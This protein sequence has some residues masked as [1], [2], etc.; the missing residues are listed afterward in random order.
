MRPK[1]SVL[2]TVVVQGLAVLT[3]LGLGALLIMVTGGDPLA[4]YGGLWEG[5]LGRLSS[6][7]ETLVWATP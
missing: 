1:S 5:S 4:A 7:S 3:A 6:I 2:E